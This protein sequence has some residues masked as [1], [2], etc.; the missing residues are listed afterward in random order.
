M[1]EDHEPG[2]NWECP[3]AQH[4]LLAERSCLQGHDRCVVVRLSAVLGAHADARVTRAVHG[5]RWVVPAVRKVPQ[6]VQWLDE[7]DAVGALLLA[8]QAL[9]AGKATSVVAGAVINVATADWLSASD[10]ASAAGGRVVALPR[11]ALI[12]A[13]RLGKAVRLVPFGAD[14]AALIGGPLALSVDKARYLLG[15]SPS[16]VSGE[17]LGAALRRDWRQLPR[18]RRS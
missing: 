1:D 6:A 12:A 11:Q 13:S 4:K 9:V 2:P 10:V 16:L 3:Y 14:R 18:A 5:Y 8:G 17:V 15:W 7:D